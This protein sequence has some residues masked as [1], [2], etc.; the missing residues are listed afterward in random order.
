LGTTQAGPVVGPETRLSVPGPTHPYK[1]I[2]RAVKT[3]G[4][5]GEGPPRTHVPSWPRRSRCSPGHAAERHTDAL[6]A[7]V[8]RSSSPPKP[9]AGVWTILCSRSRGACSGRPLPSS[10]TSHGVDWRMK[11]VQLNFFPTRFLGN[12]FVNTRPGQHAVQGGRRG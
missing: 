12:G 5:Q 4:P 9:P 6:P 10:T 11:R 3:Y 8:L 1:V 7:K 2:R